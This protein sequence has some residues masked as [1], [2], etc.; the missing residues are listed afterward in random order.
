MDP[1]GILVF[2]LFI[3][4]VLIAIIVPQIQ[5]KREDQAA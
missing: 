1:L 3:A 2:A 5:K 4:L